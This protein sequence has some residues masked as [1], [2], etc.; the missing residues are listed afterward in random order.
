MRSVQQLFLI[1]LA[2]ITSFH[3]VAET[4]GDPDAVLA[5]GRER[6]VDACAFSAMA[7][8]GKGQGMA[9][10]M[11]ENQPPDL[12]R[13]AADNGGSFRWRRSTG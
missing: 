1:I 4:A 2:F 10:S 7:L 13:L 8:S 12:T 11:L 6:Y 9:A 5:A 3:S